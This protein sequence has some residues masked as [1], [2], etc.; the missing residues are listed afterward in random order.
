MASVQGKESFS[1]GYQASLS[2]HRPKTTSSYRWA[3][4]EAMWA[5]YDY[6]MQ[7]EKPPGPQ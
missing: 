4:F 1:S 7:T 3:Q 6:A 2:H 5:I